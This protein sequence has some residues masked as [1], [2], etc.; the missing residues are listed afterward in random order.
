MVRCTLPVIGGLRVGL[1]NKK[2][3]NN[4]L[5]FLSLGGFACV[6][7]KPSSAMASQVL[8]RAVSVVHGNVARNPSLQLQL[9]GKIPRF[10]SMPFSILL[11]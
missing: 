4:V 8:T 7:A 9:N 1:A 10:F 5:V 11:L 2:D 6:K 3:Q